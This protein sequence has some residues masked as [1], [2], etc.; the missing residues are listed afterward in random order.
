MCLRDKDRLLGNI[1]LMNN[2]ISIKW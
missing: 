1:T 2:S